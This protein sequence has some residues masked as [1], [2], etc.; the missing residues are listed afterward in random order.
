[1]RRFLWI[2]PV[3]L[4]PLGVL[5]S[6]QYKFLRTLEH[7]TAEAERNALRSSLEDVTREIEM[8][9]SDDAD[10]ALDVS[11]AALPSNETLSRHFGSAA[12]PEVKTFFAA[13]FD[14]CGV[15]YFNAD[16]TRK[17]VG[18]DEAQAIDAATLVWGMFSKPLIVPYRPRTIDQRDHNNRIVLRPVTNDDGIVVGAVGLVFDEKLA[19]RSFE[20]QS[21]RM[22]R[23]KLHDVFISTKV[24]SEEHF[25]WSK[26]QR[27]YI[28]HPLGLAFSDWRIGIR[29]ACATPEEIAASNFRINALWTGIV[30]LILATAVALVFHA[31][32][33]QMRVSQMKS[34]FVSNVSHELR[35][36]LSSIR[37]FGEYM[38]LGRVKTPEKIREYGEYIETESRRLTQL[39]NNILDFSKIESAEKKY[40]FCDGDVS[41]VVAQTV[42]AFGMPL[43]EHG[44]AVTFTA[45]PSPLPPVRIDRDAFCQALVNLLDNAV[46]YSGERKEIEVSASSARGEVRIA[47]ADRG[48]GIPARE[49][50]KIFEKFYRV[51]SGLVH[52]VKGSGLGLAIVSHVV[53]AHGGR[54]E[55]ESV[56]GEG[57]IFTIVLPARAAAE[58]P[59]P[60][61]ANQPYRE[62]A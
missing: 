37:V 52:D 46:K 39:I 54:V 30:T 6:M 20:Q 38:R 16:G 57:S 59:A 11:V 24:A 21:V 56:P 60:Q 36:P 8:A 50:K 47:I 26:G 32:A 18:A 35:T 44:F 33:K 23:Q 61:P 10:R 27:A 41:E 42:S 25:G 5:L 19:Q 45:A 58:L 3:I 13:R 17:R 55:V 49:Q 2:L 12:M 1:M 22:L 28:T 4:V 34:D 29:D 62:F 53:K 43:R 48:I 31:A 51:G 7:A 15:L 14:E 40:K 9:I